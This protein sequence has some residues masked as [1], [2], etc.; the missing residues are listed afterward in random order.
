[1]SSNAKKFWMSPELLE[2]FLPF[3][4]V[5]SILQLTKAHEFTLQVL[6]V[7]SC[8]DKVTKRT[9]ELLSSDEEQSKAA[10]VAQA[11]LLK[12]MGTPE[13]LLHHLLD[14]VVKIFPPTGD[15][16]SSPPVFPFFLFPDL[17]GLSCPRLE[18]HA[19]SS[20]RILLDSV[21]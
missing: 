17:V 7:K 19:V 15:V 21:F 6:Q 16:P 9:L 12:L 18:S 10:V 1:M 14:T 11:Q 13:D 4:D 5:A 8:W 2:R 20:R 3:L